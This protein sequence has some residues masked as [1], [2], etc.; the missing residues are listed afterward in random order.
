MQHYWAEHLECSGDLDGAIDQYR[1]CGDYRSV[2]R[3][4]IFI[5]D[6]DGASKVVEETGDRAAAYHVARVLAQSEDVSINVC[7]CV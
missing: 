7:V 1:S 6:T 5:G 3:L 4:L 2:V